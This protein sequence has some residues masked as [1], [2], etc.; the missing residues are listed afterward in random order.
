MYHSLTFPIRI[1]ILGNDGK[2]R[3]FLTKY[4]DDLRKD[5]RF[6]QL[7]RVANNFFAS[8]SQTRQRKINIVTY[9][10]S[11]M[12]IYLGILYNNE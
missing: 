4:G 10:V 5:R 12:C 1:T 9:S 6:Q 3:N 2:K 11:F 7:F 8:N